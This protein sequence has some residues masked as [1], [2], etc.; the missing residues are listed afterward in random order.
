MACEKVEVLTRINRL[1]EIALEFHGEYLGEVAEDEIFD[2]SEI[3]G[4]M[5][6]DELEE[7]FG[8]EEEEDA[9]KET[10]G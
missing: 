2:A 8:E 9:T 5:R 6:F 7:E 3:L 10:I 4:E 1:S